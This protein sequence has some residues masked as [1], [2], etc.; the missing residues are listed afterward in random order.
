M[1]AHAHITNADT[2]LDDNSLVGIVREFTIPSIEMTMVDHETLG[3]VAVF[4]APSRAIQAMEA[5]IEFQS[6]DADISRR[7]LNPTVAVAFQLHQ[8]VD[9]WGADGLDRDRSH[10]LVTHV[11]L[12]FSGHE[13]G[14]AVLG[15]LAGHTAT[16]S[17]IYLRQRASKSNTSII[18]IDV[19]KQIYRVDGKAVWPG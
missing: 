5:S 17:C 12:L 8:H 10:R 14:G 13:Y 2:Y 11:K 16:A 3:A 6:I 18:E 7:I 4:S 1:Y 9:V 19:L 15:D